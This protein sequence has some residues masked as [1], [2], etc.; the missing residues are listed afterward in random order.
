MTR[1]TQLS[2]TADATCLGSRDQLGG[3]SRRISLPKLRA[4][5]AETSDQNLIE[6]TG[7][8]YGLLQLVYRHA[9]LTTPMLREIAGIHG[10]RAR[11]G[12]F[13]DDIRLLQKSGLIRPVKIADGTR[14]L[15]YCI[16][17][18]GHSYI[19]TLGDQLSCAPL[20]LSNPGNRRRILEANQDILTL[21]KALKIHNWLTDFEIRAER[22][23]RGSTCFAADYDGVLEFFLPSGPVRIGIVFELKPREKAEYEDISSRIQVEDLLHAVLFVMNQKRIL[24]HIAPAF[25]QKCCPVFFVD[26]DEFLCKSAAAEAFFWNNGELETESIARLL[27][28]SAARVIQEIE[29]TSP[30]RFSSATRPR[31]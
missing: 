27:A 28:Q 24:S 2:T 26:R 8:Q 23:A 19:K 10:I 6:P 29:P 25:Q 22:N 9:L 7:K 21:G 12:S 1:D 13:S 4:E 18:E 16:T 5:S 14:R 17:E 30:F 15:A 31:R 3:S 20:D 11:G